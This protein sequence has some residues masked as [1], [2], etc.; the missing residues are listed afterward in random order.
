MLIPVP[1]V[2]SVV[3]EDGTVILDMRLDMMLT[4]NPTAGYIWDR[5]KQGKI[6][7]E[8]IR[9]LSADTGIDIVVVERDVHEFLEQLK[10]KH[11]LV[12][13]E[14]LRSFGPFRRFGRAL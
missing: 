6:I 13:A 14:P 11:V 3:D 10:A 1:H 4:L 2:R 8:I 9:D 5:L 7:D 12:E